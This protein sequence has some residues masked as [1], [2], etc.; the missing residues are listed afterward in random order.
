M[1]GVDMDAEPQHVV[2]RKPSG[3]PPLPP[4]E[5]ADR[6]VFLSALDIEVLERFFGISRQSPRAV[7]MWLAEQELIRR[8]TAKSNSQCL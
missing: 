8:E 2:V 4:G 1:Y 6:A 3:R 5:K 7:I